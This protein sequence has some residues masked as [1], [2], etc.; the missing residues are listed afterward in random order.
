MKTYDASEIRN[1]GVVGHGHCG[2]TSL[3]SAFL[4]D[5]GAVNRFGK[6]DDGTTVTD[7]DEESIHRKKSVSSSLCNLEW[8]KNKINLIDTPGYGA[9]LHETRGSLRVADG[10]V[11]V[12]SAVAGVEVSTTKAWSYADEFGLSRIVVI[13]K[14]DRERASFARCLES[15]RSSFGRGAIAIQMPVGEEKEFSGVVDLIRMKALSWPHDGSGKL[16]EG[17][18]PPALQAD[19]TAAREQLV[20]GVAEND[21]KLMERYLE[22]GTLTDDELLG[23]LRSAV[24][25]KKV[26]PV[27]CSAAT[28]N[29]GIQPILDAIVRYVP[30]PAQRGDLTGKDAA[31]HEVTRRPAPSEPFS[32]QVFKTVVDLFAGKISYFR[33]YSGT[34][35]ADSTI[36]NASKAET[37]RVGAVDLVMG[38]AITS[39]PELHAG[40]IGA[41][42]KLKVTQTGDTLVS[43]KAHALEYERVHFAEP[44]ISWAIEPKS[45][46]D[47]EKLSAALH[48]LLD[49]DPMLRI[50]RDPQTKEMLISGSGQEHVEV[51]VARLKRQGVECAL[52]LPKIPYRETITK[53]VKYVEY[54]HKKQTGGAGQYARV[55]I[56]VEPLKTGTYEF[57]DRIVGG[58]IDQHFRPSVDK[59][60][61]ARMAEGVIAGFP[62][63]GVRVSLVDGKTHPVDSKDIAFQVAGR[64]AFKKAVAEAGP[65]L[66]E[67]IMHVEVIVPEESYGDI[68]GDLNSR[69]GRVQGM[70]SKSGNSIIKA[71][72]PMAEMLNY[73]ATINSITG[74]RGEY[75]MEF[76]HY[77]EVPTHLREKIVHDAKAATKSDETGHE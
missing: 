77:D 18:I 22:A 40:D 65:T 9:F 56:D 68:L 17:P 72:V 66:L 30:S 14:M 4:F 31:G 34:V 54:T 75:H 67:P 70:D 19:A 60:I 29:I 46:G 16:T 53:T 20:D 35:K 28:A 39:V 25:Q 48:K 27:L 33:V 42:A 59:G 61:Q 50:S 3:V 57:V 55:F 5:A 6:V 1:V 8:D 45:R 76:A 62:V 69:R 24:E 26:F 51:A 15:I 32:A 71:Q 73:S 21:D 52:K 11:V 43:D 49:A 47:E 63:V 36:Y 64:E 13:N 74:G 12:V 7:F 41:F 23:G 10:A 58:V 37:E 2:K 38:K 44:A